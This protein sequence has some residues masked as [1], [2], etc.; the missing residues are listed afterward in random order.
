MRRR[1]DMEAD[2]IP[3]FGHKIGIARQLEPA[4]PVRLRNPPVMAALRN[5]GGMGW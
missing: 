1:I 2:N 5:R 3:K 4:H